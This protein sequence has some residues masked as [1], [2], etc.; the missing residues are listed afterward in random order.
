VTAPT[1]EADPDCTGSASTT[2]NADRRPAGTATRATPT[3]TPTAT[4]T[5]PV[6]EGR[7]LRAE[8]RPFGEISRETW[9]RLAG[10]NPWA[11]PF[12][13]W[14]FHR[15]W[16]D[17]YGADAH[18]ETMVV[19]D[20]AAAGSEPGARSGIPLD[21]I[22]IIPLMH[23]HVVEERDAETHTSIRHAAPLDL[24]PLAATA[25]AVYFGAS[26]HADYA[27]ILGAPADLP[28]VAAALADAMCAEALD[29]DTHPAPWDAIDLR[30]IRSAD[31][32]GPALAKAFGAR[33]MAEGWTLNFEP[34]DVCPVAALPEGADID[35]FL[36]TLG[37]KERHEIRRK[38]RRVDAAG[39]VAFVESPDPLEDLEAFIDF[40]QAKWGADGLFPDTP[41][42]AESR[43]MFRRMFELFGADGPLR[44]SFLTLDGRRI[45]ASVFFETDD[46]ILYYNAGLSPEARSLSPGVVMVERLVQRALETGKRRFDFL[47]GNEPY[48]YEW[49][50]V[51]EPIQ[52]LLVRRTAD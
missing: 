24:T 47:R 7:R 52:R 35:A 36:A 6:P 5:S 1:L 9:D 3:A 37:K 27:T 12:S 25:K 23:R 15:A 28:D 32:V 44:L 21:P 13:A 14:A 46:S 45:A 11:T 31:P 10:L 2:A 50:A 30:R 34:E 38:V 51:D 18:E 22:A 8:L 33:E 48:K 39:T 17:A 19:V 42:G 49:G 20:P 29:N 43:V 26:Y 4:A 16:W 41:G 40:H